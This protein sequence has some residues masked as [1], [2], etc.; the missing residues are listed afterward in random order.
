KLAS[1][2]MET[3]DSSNDVGL[4]REISTGSPGM[5]AGAQAIAIPSPT[6]EL[7]LREGQ[8]ID[9]G[10]GTP[11]LRTVKNFT[12]I[13][14]VS[15]S[16]GHGRNLAP[17]AI[18]ARVS[19]TDGTQAIIQFEQDFPGFSVIAKT[20]DSITGLPGDPVFKKFG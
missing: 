10:S 2:G 4:W 15:R 11:D 18:N 7:L 9:V 19:F 6:A 13:K 1:G 20:G 17:G 5:R 3:V 14:S 8:Q 12:C 16:P